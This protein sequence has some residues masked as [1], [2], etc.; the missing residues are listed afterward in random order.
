M[1]LAIKMCVMVAVMSFGTAQ[2]NWWGG[3]DNYNDGYYNDN[4]WPVWTPMYWAEEMS[5]NGW[6]N[7]WGGNNGPGYGGGPFNGSGFNMPWANNGSGFSMPWDNNG[8]GFSM[9]WNN[10]G[11]NG[12][13]PWNWGGGTPYY[14]G[15]QGYGAPNG[16]QGYYGAP[17][18][19]GAYPPSYY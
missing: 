17:Y 3:N 7:D 9:P 6:G 10:N 2:A 15:Q 16:G 5:G 14:G 12:G 19:G 4:D 8:S 13:G 18:G 11:G 1:K